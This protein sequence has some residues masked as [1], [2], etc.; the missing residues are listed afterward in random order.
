VV[1][2]VTGFENESDF[3]KNCNVVQ[4]EYLSQAS[5]SLL[6]PGL[7]PKK[8]LSKISFVKKKQPL[9]FKNNLFKIDE[10]EAEEGQ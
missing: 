10:E 3:K 4:K 8:T 7:H 9:D 6:V 2:K 5:K 1:L